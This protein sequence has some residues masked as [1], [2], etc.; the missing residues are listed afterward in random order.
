MKSFN[1]TKQETA[2]S[3]IT[4][5]IVS[6]FAYIIFALSEPK[7]SLPLPLFG[8]LGFFGGAI[9]G[10]IGVKKINKKHKEE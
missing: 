1:I 8:T 4:G 2:T 3:L 9:G 10:L 7:P 6:A 5:I